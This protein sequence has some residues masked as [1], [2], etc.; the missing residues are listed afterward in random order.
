MEPFGVIRKNWNDTEK[1]SM[2]PAQ[3]WHAL[4]ENVSLFF[5]SGPEIHFFLNSFSPELQFS[6]ADSQSIGSVPW[7]DEK[8]FF[9]T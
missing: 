4:I 1:I 8:K 5:S 6:F 2:A 3:G 7:S 9:F